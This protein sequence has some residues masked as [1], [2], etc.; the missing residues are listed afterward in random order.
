MARIVFLFPKWLVILNGWKRWMLIEDKSHWTKRSIEEAVAR[1]R[2]NRAGFDS[3]IRLVASFWPNWCWKWASGPIKADM[4]GTS[5]EA[6]IRLDMSE[7]L[8]A[9]LSCQLTVQQLV[10]LAMMTIA[11]PWQNVFV[12]I[13]LYHLAGRNW[14]PIRKSSHVTAV[15]D[16]DSDRWT[17]ILSTL[18]IQLLLLRLTLALGMKLYW[19]WERIWKL[20]IDWNHT[21]A[22]NFERLQCS[23]WI[24]ILSKGFAEIVDLMLDEVNQTLAKKTSR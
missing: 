18:R 3:E 9:F 17:E 12:G 24:S 5:K 7:Y 21:S 20:W 16:D 8:T 14:K 1:Y 23:H 6:I 15:L 11:T 4:F 13:L 22:Q 10:M 19:W 2:R